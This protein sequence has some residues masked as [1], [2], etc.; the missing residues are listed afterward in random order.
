MLMLLSLF[1][2]ELHLTAYNGLY[3]ERWKALRYYQVHVTCMASR[4]LLA[5]TV[6]WE[7]TQF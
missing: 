4:F 6:H 3:Y 2:Y 7:N 1:Y 5:S